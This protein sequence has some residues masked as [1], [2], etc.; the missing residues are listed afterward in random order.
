ML[1]ARLAVSGLSPAA[2]AA[3]ARAETP[4]LE[5]GWGGQ[6]GETSPGRG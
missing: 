4:A 6:V 3:N 1:A 2:S 5:A